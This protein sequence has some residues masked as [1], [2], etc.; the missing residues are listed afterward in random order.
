MHICVLN[1]KWLPTQHAFSNSCAF[2]NPALLKEQFYLEI[3][4]DLLRPVVVMSFP[5]VRIILGLRI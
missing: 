2:Q 1:Q 5:W 4:M 3:L